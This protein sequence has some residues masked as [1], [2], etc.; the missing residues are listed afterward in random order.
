MENHR[1][2][3]AHFDEKQFVRKGGKGQNRLRNDALPLD[4]T[5]NPMS[6]VQEV[7]NTPSLVENMTYPSLFG[8]TDD[9]GERVRM[10]IDSPA[11]VQSEPPII[12]LDNNSTRGAGSSMPHN[13]DPQINVNVDSIDNESTNCSPMNSE[14]DEFKRYKDEV[15]SLKKQLNEK[16]LARKKALKQDKV[17]AGRIKNLKKIE[18][19]KEYG[20]HIKNRDAKI[21]RK[22]IENKDKVIARLKLKD[23]IRD[24]K[25]KE[26]VKFR[27]QCEQLEKE[28]QEFLEMQ[29]NHVKLKK[30]EENE[31]QSCISLFYKSPKAYRW[32]REQR[33]LKLAC[34]TS[35]KIYLINLYKFKFTR[36][37]G[38]S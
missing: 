37:F 13:V 10:N 19:M 21:L 32:L 4:Y 36:S 20:R 2:C 18:R 17:Y 11:L 8:F 5:G 27:N 26:A 22:K 15:E 35:Y 12:D 14:S 38:S 3:S 23:K 34:I 28:A 29:L 7:I 33:K 16:D 31:K 1:L 30:W 6:L 24:E 9:N 25:C